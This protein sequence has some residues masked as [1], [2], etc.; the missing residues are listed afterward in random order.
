MSTPIRRAYVGIHRV[1]GVDERADASAALRLGDDVVDERRL[2]RRLRA[3]DLD[4]APARKAADAESHVERERAGRHGADRHLRAVA[5]PHHRAL[6]ELPLDLAECDVECFLALH[7]LI[8]LSALPSGHDS[9]TSY[10][11]PDGCRRESKAAASD[12]ANAPIAGSGGSSRGRSRNRR[13]V[14]CGSHG[15]RS[16]SYT[17][18]RSRAALDAVGERRRRARS[19]P[20]ARASRRSGSRGSARRRARTARSPQPR[21]TGARRPARPRRRGC[22]PRNASVT[23]KLSGTRPRVRCRSPQRASSSATSSGTS[24]ARNSLIRSSPPTVAGAVTPMC[25]DSPTIAARGGARLRS[26]GRGSSRGLPAAP[27][28]RRA[29]RRARTACANTRP[30]GL[31]GV[32]PPGPATPVTATATSAPSR[33]RAPAAIAAATSAETAPCSAMS[34]AGTSSSASFTS[35]A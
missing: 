25:A 24:S 10:L 13:T 2:A 33:S 14:T 34:S 22:A 3:E 30:T 20:R 35:F 1:L 32:P 23:W 31:S 15:R 27:C 11:A 16:R 6:P 12:G 19:G 17:P 26:R 4:D 29:R 7:S 8:L 5:H 28:E 9:S 21:G 18:R